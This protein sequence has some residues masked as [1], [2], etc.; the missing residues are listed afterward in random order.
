MIAGNV[1]SL[2]TAVLLVLKIGGYAQMTW[3]EAMVPLALGWVIALVGASIEVVANRCR[4]H[5]A[6]AKLDD[7]LQKMK[8]EK[9]KSR[10]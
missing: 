8:E 10:S 4:Q 2:A 6:K 1:F 7:I 5:Q 9:A 3:V